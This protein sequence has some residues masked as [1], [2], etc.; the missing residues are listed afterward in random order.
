MR[1]QTFL[2]AA[3]ATILPGL[4]AAQAGTF[5]ACMLEDA[6]GQ[7][8]NVGSCE[9]KP[10]S[11][12]SE[13]DCQK[14]FHWQADDFVTIIT[15]GGPLTVH[16]GRS[17]NGQE[18]YAPQALVQSD[19]RDCIYNAVTDGLFC[20][21][22]DPEGEAHLL[23]ADGLDAY[24]ALMTLA[25]ASVVPTAEPDEQSET[26]QIDEVVD[27][28][29]AMQG[30]YRPVPSWNCGEIGAEGGATAILGQTLYGLETECALSNARV[31]G[32]QGALLLDASCS[33]EGST[34]EEEYLLRRDEWGSLM[35]SSLQGAALWQ[36]CE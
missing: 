31:I 6:S 23:A 34:W 28:F 5:G 16:D 30:K 25:G 14:V 24:E 21:V 7:P 3:A 13:E 18:A 27:I 15:G 10:A 26:A 33:G 19:P 2:I 4:A 9:L 22:N 35:V 29:E 17:M 1:F 36:A 8:I 11:C 20:F 12:N 32:R